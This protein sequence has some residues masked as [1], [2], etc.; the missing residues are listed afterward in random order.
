MMIKYHA[1]KSIPKPA[2][3]NYQ[4][5]LN[6]VG[7]E[8][9]LEPGHYEYIFR[10]EDFVRLGPCEQNDKLY[11]GLLRWVS[12]WPE[13]PLNVRF[14]INPSFLYLPIPVSYKFILLQNIC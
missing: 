13:S 3:L 1:I 14:L 7:N 8:Q 5:V 12:H 10:I 4:S 2:K 6:Y 9:P 11:D